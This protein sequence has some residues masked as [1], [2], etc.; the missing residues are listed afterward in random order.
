MQSGVV[1][2]ITTCS[3]DN[4]AVGSHPMIENTTARESPKE[5]KCAHASDSDDDIHF[6]RFTPKKYSAIVQIDSMHYATPIIH[7]LLQWAFHKHLYHLSV[8][9]HLQFYPIDD[10]HLVKS[11]FQ[12]AYSQHSIGGRT[13]V[14]LFNDA[15]PGHASNSQCDEY[16]PVEDNEFDYPCNGASFYVDPVYSMNSITKVLGKVIL[17]FSKSPTII[18]SMA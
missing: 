10:W 9:L 12:M 4:L 16:H 3:L 18:S 7:L 6:K 2:M 17:D 13:D 5:P 11:E 15:K 14:D 8:C 1:N